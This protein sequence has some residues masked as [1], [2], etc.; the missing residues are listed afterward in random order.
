MDRTLELY[1]IKGSGLRIEKR[2]MGAESGRG[3]SRKKQASSWKDSNSKRQEGRRV[4]LIWFPFL[5][6]WYRFYYLVLVD[7]EL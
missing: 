7:L 2:I 4:L 3:K 6:C 5:C 1:K